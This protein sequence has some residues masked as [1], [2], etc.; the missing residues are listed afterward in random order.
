MVDVYLSESFSVFVF[1]AILFL[2]LSFLAKNCPGLISKFPKFG[3]YLINGKLKWKKSR[4][5]AYGEKSQNE[6]IK[7]NWSNS[8][9]VFSFIFFILALIELISSLIGYKAF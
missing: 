8:Y 6:I 4:A 7:T 3:L 9:L 1:C 5:D 2:L